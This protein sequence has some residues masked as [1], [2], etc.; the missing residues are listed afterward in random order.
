MANDNKRKLYDALSQDYDMGSYEQ[1]C[2]DLNDEGKRR[3]LYNATSQDYDLG[4]W[5]SFSQQLGYGQAA[6]PAP[7]STPAPAAAPEQ[8][9]ATSYFKLRRGGKDFT[10]PT[11]E[12]N[13]AGGLYDWAK[14]HPGAPLR[15]Y[16][17]WT[18]ENG[19]PFDGHVDLSVAH[20]RSKKRGY[21]YTTTNTPIETPPGK[22]GSD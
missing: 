21:K 20:D 14:A 15:V 22:V 12:V 11:D 5:E 2:A 19:K 17:S 9:K 13:A 4:T 10:V 18:N 6:T 7:A 1:F 8:P 16:M 3:K